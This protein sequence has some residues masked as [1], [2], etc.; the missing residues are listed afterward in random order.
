MTIIKALSKEINGR[1]ARQY[2][3][4]LFDDDGS[5]MRNWLEEEL[6]APDLQVASGQ[7]GVPFHPGGD[8]WARKIDIRPGQESGSDHD[9]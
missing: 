7:M 2:L 9:G 4:V 5:S 8:E 6:G 1:I 3:L